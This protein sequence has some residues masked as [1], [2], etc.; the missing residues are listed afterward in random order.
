MKQIMK[1]LLCTVLAFS[2]TGC[3]HEGSM[4]QLMTKH[5][6]G[7]HLPEHP[8]SGKGLVYVI[9]DRGLYLYDKGFYVKTT[10][11]L[12]QKVNFSYVAVDKDYYD[13]NTSSMTTM[14]SVFTFGLVEKDEAP[15]KKT[16][17]T[18]APGQYVTLSLEPGYYE[19]AYQVMVPSDMGLNP[20]PTLVHVEAGKISYVALQHVTGVERYVN[21]LYLRHVDRKL[22][23]PYA[24]S[25]NF[26]KQP[27][28]LIK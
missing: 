16:F 27:V 4:E 13:V 23:G 6:E 15:G 14:A 11:T 26:D 8:Q 10:T 25:H 12:P 21:N 1:A 20:R 18:L 3:S 2:L 17:A 24:L 28:I 22:K 19:M 5:L 7:F 9:Y